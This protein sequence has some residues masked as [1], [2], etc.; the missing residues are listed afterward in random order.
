MGNRVEK[1]SLGLIVEKLEFQ[2]RDLEF[3]G[4]GRKSDIK[5]AFSGEC[6]GWIRARRALEGL[7]PSPGLR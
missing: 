3:E 6:G 1:G 7:L 2:T 5:V 4:A